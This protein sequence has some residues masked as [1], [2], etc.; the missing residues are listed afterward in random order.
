MSAL[1]KSPAPDLTF[2]TDAALRPPT[3][4]YDMTNVTEFLMRAIVFQQP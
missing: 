2:L 1:G 4:G 3:S